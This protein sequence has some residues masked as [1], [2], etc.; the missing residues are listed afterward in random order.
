MTIYPSPWV[1]GTFPVA[2]APFQVA[3]PR[4]DREANAGPIIHLPCFD[5]GL[6]HSVSLL[7]L[8]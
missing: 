2:F 7:G 5:L 8:G 1:P 3:F 6:C 4:I